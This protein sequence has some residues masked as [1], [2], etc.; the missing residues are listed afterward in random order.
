MAIYE[1]IWDRQ[2]GEV[3]KSLPLKHTHTTKKAKIKIKEQKKALRDIVDVKAEY[4]H[5]DIL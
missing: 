2:K 4:Y 3:P 1:S 5:Y